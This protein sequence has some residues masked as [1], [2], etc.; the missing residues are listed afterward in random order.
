MRKN[1]KGNL[2]Q[3][4]I[5]LVTVAVGLSI[6]FNQLGIS[7]EKKSAPPAQAQRASGAPASPGAQGNSGTQGTSGRP[8]STASSPQ[9]NAGP[10]PTGAAAPSATNGARRTITVMAHTIAY[11]TLSD[12]TKLHGDVVSYNETRIYPNLAGFTH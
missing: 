7:F 6:V 9:G 10:P 3:I 12:L 1:I 4:I 2:P 11:G 5:V 8:Q